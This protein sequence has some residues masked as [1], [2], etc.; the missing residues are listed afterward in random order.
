MA[1]EIS[2]LLKSGHETI[3]RNWA[4]KVMADRRVHSDARLSY[5]Q[6]VDHVPQIVEE[7][8]N[9]LI[10]QP[11]VGQML[12]QGEEHGRQRWQQGY[13]L[14]EVIRELTL[15]RQTV[16][17]FIDTYRGAL[18]RQSVEQLTKSF[19]KINGFIDEELYKTV[20]AYLAAPAHAQHALGIDN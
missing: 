10:A 7:L 14:K 15:L 18:P 6:L 1:E 8:R 16:I 12:F 5:L 17:E 9:A 4:D 11:P 13:E 2:C 20:E 19:Q 3:V